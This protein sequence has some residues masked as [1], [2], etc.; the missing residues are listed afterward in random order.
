MRF[1]VVET[2]RESALG[3]DPSAGSRGGET[4]CPGCHSPIDEQYVKAEGCAGKFGVQLMAVVCEPREGRG[5]RYLDPAAEWESAFSDKQLSKRAAKIAT[6]NGFSVPDEPL[7][8][9]PRSF[10]VQNFGFTHWRDV[11]T[12]RQLV[13]MVAFTAAIR[14]SHKDMLSRGYSR[15]T[16]KAVATCLSMVLGRLANQCTSLCRWQPEFIAGMLG[17]AGL[18]MIMDFAEVN[19]PA[20][21]LRAFAQYPDVPPSYAALLCLQDGQTAVSTRLSP[22]LPIMTVARTR[23]CQIIF[24]SGIRDL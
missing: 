12:P 9:N 17:D 1:Q 19:P 16:A 3:F 18:P 2:E 15:D 23:T 24:L 20:I 5:K 11:F 7:E 4:V 8:A 22:I 14:N 10:D 6:D 21:Q 13:A